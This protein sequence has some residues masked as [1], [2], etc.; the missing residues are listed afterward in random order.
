M[1]SEDIAACVEEDEKYKYSDELSVLELIMLGDILIEFNF[2]AEAP[3][4]P[5]FL[6]FAE[7]N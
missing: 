1:A 3:A 4:C 5:E 6:E 7:C 2:L